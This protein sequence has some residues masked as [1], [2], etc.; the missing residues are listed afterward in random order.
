MNLNAVLSD[1]QPLADL[2]AMVLLHSLW[3][4]ALVSLLVAAVQSQQSGANANGR[5][6]AALLGLI[7]IPLLSVVVAVAMSDQGAM[8]DRGGLPNDGAI[9]DG[10]VTQASD[11]S[12]VAHE[13]DRPA[14]EHSAV[15]AV[16]QSAV[17]HEAE[18]RG[19]GVASSGVSA[20][21]VKRVSVA[22]WLVGFGLMLLR[23]VRSH[24]AAYRIIKAAD[25]PIPDWVQPVF[26]GIAQQLGLGG[27]VLLRVGSSFSGP[28][29]CGLLQPVVFL[30]TATLQQLSPEA[31]R[32]ILCHE[33]A[34][35]HRRDLLI[36]FVERLV[37]SCFFFNPA[38]WWM[39]RQIRNEREAACDAIAVQITQQP[40]SVATALL[41]SAE[42]FAQ[43]VT[44]LALA[45]DGGSL[46]DRV[47]RLVDPNRP[48]RFQLP[49]TSL[50]ALVAFGTLAFTSLTIG[51]TVV[52]IQ[53]REALTP[54]EQVQA[55]VEA[56]ESA[57]AQALHPVTETYVT[58]TGRF[59][60]ADGQPVEKGYTYYHSQ[61]QNSGTSGSMNVS[62]GGQF[63]IKTP[64]YA[65]VS[66]GSNL[67]NVVVR[68]YGPVVLTDNDYDFGDLVL[69]SGFSAAMRFVD[70]DGNP[71]AD[72]KIESATLW[73]EDHKSGMG[74]SRYTNLQSDQ[75]GMIALTHLGD[76]KIEY[77]VRASGFEFDRRELQ[78]SEDETL[79][80]KLKRSSPF[81]GQL[82]S[83][84]SGQPVAG[85]EIHLVHRGVPF[86][87]IND[88]RERF[89]QRED[90]GQ[91]PD[92][93]MVT[94]DQGRF[95]LDT[96]RKDTRY[97]FIALH[98]DYRPLVL[99]QVTAGE[100]R[101]GVQM[102]APLLVRG[103]L[104]GDL[105]K[106][107]TDRRTGLP[108]FWFRNPIPVGTGQDRQTY[109]SM[110]RCRID[111]NGRF[112]LPLLV[113]GDVKLEI[114]ERP[115]E[116]RLEE[117][118]TDLAID[119]DTPT[120]VPD[121]QQPIRVRLIPAQN[122]PLRG[123]VSLSWS[124]PAD[125]DFVGKRY[126]HRKF[127]AAEL[128]EWKAPA[129][130]NLYLQ[131]KGLVGSWVDEGRLGT[132][133]AGQQPDE[134]EVTLQTAGVFSGQI[135]D[136]ND[137]PAGHVSISV[138]RYE[139]KRHHFHLDETIEHPNG[140]F[141]IGPLPL[142]A[143]HTYRAFVFSQTTWQVAFV[144]EFQ[145]TAKQP[146]FHQPILFPASVELTGRVVDS[147]G[148]PVAGARIRQT[149]NIRTSSRTHGPSIQTD[150]DGRFRV[151]VSAPN[152]EGRFSAT[153]SPTADLAG[154]TFEYLPA[155]IAANPDLGDLVLK[156]GYSIA[157][158][159]VDESGNPVDG[160]S[161]HLMPVDFKSAAYRAGIDDRTEADGRFSLT[162]IEGVMQRLSVFGAELVKATAPAYVD[163][164]QF[165]NKQYA[166]DPQKVDAELVI[167]VR[168]PQ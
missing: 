111:E 135:V 48:P 13:S 16:Q 21:T 9:Q 134:F 67:A 154:L 128:L 66:V 132:V 37:E 152:I 88:P 108:F 122:Q 4:G 113:A 77:S 40:L 55:V 46:E 69:D 23:L 120:P 53:V 119:L 124:V 123:S 34:H 107:Q 112:D 153:I 126:G 83:A 76:T 160:V 71:I 75:N 8:S 31:I 86:S 166:I 161:V 131:T 93:I 74:V 137:K 146:V 155:D 35:I 3:I 62:E 5:Y 11:H 63:S 151:P 52:A 162:G 127:E 15:A 32:I 14:S 143:N 60:R 121:A 147:S 156:P 145:V 105:T 117:S 54:A 144:D 6:A 100:T 38:V 80:W 102:Q 109:N 148:Q 89:L 168:K 41:D 84:E 65:T 78:F 24:F 139:G 158:R 116:L 2:W 73:T 49:W 51:T 61:S 133:E 70:E 64:A 33:L 1:L 28:M 140:Q 17:G 94:D 72:A 22:A 92:D 95:V 90:T 129:G 12:S 91:I 118:L 79:E 44:G 96:L 56:V 18:S 85:A 68:N 98:A 10:E 39:C 101:E 138:D 50:V 59:V 20:L 45:A 114:P 82:V 36:S 7:A 25:S 97:T 163:Q 43:P 30:P 27:K 19:A 164:D 130:A 26:D 157:G 110:F 149:W 87:H 150:P 99:D 103:T 141:A 29:V 142:G 167:T 57:D 136:S 81:T 125:I 47:E 115:V 58:V 165:G 104:S 106:L 159:V 42:A